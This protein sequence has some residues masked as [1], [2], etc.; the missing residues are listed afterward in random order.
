M[1]PQPRFV[2]ERGDRARF[3]NMQQEF[4]IVRQ[5]AMKLHRLEVGIKLQ[6]GSLGAAGHIK[7]AGVSKR[8]PARVLYFHVVD[9]FEHEFVGRTW[10]RGGEDMISATDVQAAPVDDEVNGRSRLKLVALAQVF[11]GDV[12]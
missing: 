6:D 8:H 5:V 4:W 12:I 2:L 7:V 10:E 9:G 11:A 1:C 3:L